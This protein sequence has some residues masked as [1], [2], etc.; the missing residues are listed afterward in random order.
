MNT[1]KPS[2]IRT[3]IQSAGMFSTEPLTEEARSTGS[4]GKL[5]FAKERGSSKGRQ[6]SDSK[7]SKNSKTLKKPMKMKTEYTPKDDYLKF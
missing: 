7:D 3:S 5:Y 1:L 6:S 2:Q 4:F